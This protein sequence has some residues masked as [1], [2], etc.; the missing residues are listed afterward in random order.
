[1]GNTLLELCGRG[2]FRV[3]VNRVDIAGDCGEQLDILFFD[4][5]GI[6]GGL[7]YGDFIVGKVTYMW[8]DPGLLQYNSVKHN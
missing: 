4:K 3:E 5:L 8:Y 6:A 7:P 1:M 2:K